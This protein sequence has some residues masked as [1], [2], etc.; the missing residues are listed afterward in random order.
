MSFQTRFIS[1]LHFGHDHV[2]K[3]AN[4]CYKHWPKNAGNENSVC[5]NN[6]IWRKPDIPE[7]I[8]E[9]DARII[10]NWNKVV[11]SDDHTY[12]LGDIGISKVSFGY[13]WDC[14]HQLNGT[15]HLVPGNHDRA[16]LEWCISQKSGQ[17]NGVVQTPNGPVMPAVSGTN[18]AKL[19]VEMPYL[20]K[21]VTVDGGKFSETVIMS[22]YPIWA[23]D[24][25]GFGS[26]LVYGHIHN[27]YEQIDVFN[28]MLDST[29][30]SYTN[31]TVKPKSYD[32]GCMLPWMDFT[33]RTIEELKAAF[34]AD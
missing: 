7:T 8:Q 20:K 22:H 1:D 31:P 3:F 19:V 5:L 30:F 15:V 4:E 16:F 29:P 17:F 28:K 34:Q 27:F 6:L 23:F 25:C 2:I 21:T 24:S 11:K 10:T 26:I 14:L 12:I 33:P 9:W 18:K 32:V 13:L